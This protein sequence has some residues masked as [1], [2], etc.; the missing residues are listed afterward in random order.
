MQHG[1]PD[2]TQSV[3]TFQTASQA[4]AATRRNLR[5]IMCIRQKDTCEIALLMSDSVFNYIKVTVVLLIGS[6]LNTA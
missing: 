5:L 1:G 3:Q 4:T 2:Y 6:F